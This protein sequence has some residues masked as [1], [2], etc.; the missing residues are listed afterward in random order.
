M[1]CMYVCMYLCMFVLA[2]AT[3]TAPSGRGTAPPSTMAGHLASLFPPVALRW[4]HKGCCRRWPIQI[5]VAHAHTHS[6]TLLHCEKGVTLV[7]RL[8]MKKKYFLKNFVAFRYICICFT[9]YL[10]TFNNL[11]P[12]FFHCVLL[13]VSEKKLAKLH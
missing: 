8:P 9:T 13:L 10:S 7:H 3:R 1:V 4:S 11:I 6:H 12:F 2:T 5:T